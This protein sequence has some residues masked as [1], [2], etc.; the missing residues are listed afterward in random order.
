MFTY[1]QV[2]KLAVGTLH[3]FTSQASYLHWLLISK[4]DPLSHPITSLRRSLLGV[5]ENDIDPAVFLLSF[6]ASVVGE[7]A[8]LAKALG[9]QP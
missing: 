5:V 3:C 4:S 9:G 1:G 2:D 7:T 8:G 6:Q